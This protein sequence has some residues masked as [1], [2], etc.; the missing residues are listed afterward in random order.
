MT[1]FVPVGLFATPIW[2]AFVPTRTSIHF[3]SVPIQDALDLQYLIGVSVS[4][5]RAFPHTSP[6]LQ[7]A[8]TEHFTL[9]GIKFA[10][11]Q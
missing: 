6:L 3:P 4:E 1:G 10:P 5:Q 7:F 8:F 2:S 9:V 11:I